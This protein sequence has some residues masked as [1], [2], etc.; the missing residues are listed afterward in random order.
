MSRPWWG[1]DCPEVRSAV[2]VVYAI[3][4]V[5]AT[6]LVAA[7]TGCARTAAAKP[8]PRTLPDLPPVAILVCPRQATLT[9]KHYGPGEGGN[10]FER[11]VVWC[12]P[13]T[14]PAVPPPSTQP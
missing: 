14:S 1:N 8:T 9:A 3:I 10:P 6:V 4:L 7:A 5:A 12:Q 11:L 13:S 2:A